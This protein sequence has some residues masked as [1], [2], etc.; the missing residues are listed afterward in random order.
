MGQPKVTVES[1]TRE[2]GAVSRLKAEVDGLSILKDKEHYTGSFSRAQA[3][4]I[5]LQ[6]ELED[7]RRKLLCRLGELTAKERN[8]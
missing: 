7:T 3:F 8:L 4:D 6:G 1:V 2:L 5:F